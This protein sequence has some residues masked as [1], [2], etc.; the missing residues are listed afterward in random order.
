MVT[1]TC[2]V[3]HSSIRG[4]TDKRFCND[5][6]RNTYNNA[7]K[8]PQNALMRNINHQLSRN[9]RILL[10]QLTGKH[11]IQKTSKKKLVNA[12]FD[13]T[14]CTSARTAKDGTIIYGCYETAFIQLNETDVLILLEEESLGD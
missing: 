4:R 8:S 13:L 9:R 2:P 6:C 5:Y 11:T 10:E 3:C 7:K 12:G 1:K 14:F